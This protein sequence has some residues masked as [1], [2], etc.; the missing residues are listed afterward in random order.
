M[1][2]LVT[3]TEIAR[4]AESTRQA[5]TNWRSPHC[6]LLPSRLR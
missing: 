5:V 2:S 3:M 6:V 1:E 4:S